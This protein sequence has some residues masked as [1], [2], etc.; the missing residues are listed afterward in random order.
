MRV[1]VVGT[2]GSGK[3]TFARRL[4]GQ[5]GVPHIEL[6]AINWGPDW[7]DLNTHEPQTFK[8]RVAAAAAQDRWVCDGNYGLVRDIVMARATHL[9]WLD[10]SRSLVVRRVALRSLHR[11][12]TRTELWPGTGNRESFARW[13]E[14]D[15]P[16]RWAWDTHARRRRDYS[17]LIADPTL[18][19]VHIYRVQDPG[20]LRAVEVELL[21]RAR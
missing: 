9:V 5:T 8:R 18:A 13:L 14:K 20:A 7:R 19:D 2:S 3:S 16:I 17:A 12:L 1:A 10:Y 11:T 4:A 6:D 21:S 15:H